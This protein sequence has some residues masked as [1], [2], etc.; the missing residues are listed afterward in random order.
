MVNRIAEYLKPKQ[1]AKKADGGP[2]ATA[3]ARR[4]VEMLW[5]SLER[6]V[7]NHPGE[8][9]AAAFA[10]GVTAAWWMKRR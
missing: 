7:T 9:L 6:S 10:L 5:E 1:R 4:K 8:W 3:D 2:A